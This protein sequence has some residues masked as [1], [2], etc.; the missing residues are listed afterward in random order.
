MFWN[1]KKKKK[2]VNCSFAIYFDS[3]GKK[4]KLWNVKH[5]IKFLLHLIH[6]SK[7]SLAVEHHDELHIRYI[8]DCRA[9]TGL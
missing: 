1:S 9:I 3:G 4:N 6:K 2:H 8:A 5:Q 7:R